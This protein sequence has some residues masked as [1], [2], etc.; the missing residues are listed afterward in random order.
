[1]NP[2]IRLTDDGTL[3]DLVFTHASHVH[4]ERMDTGHWWM[5][6]LLPDGRQFTLQFTSRAPIAALI[7][8]EN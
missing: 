8:Q 3:D 2:D 5:G 6:I 4:L 1:M 7:E